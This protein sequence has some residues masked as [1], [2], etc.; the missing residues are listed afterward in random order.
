MGLG[1]YSNNSIFATAI[2]T[3]TFYRSWDALMLTLDTV[4]PGS[5]VSVGG[6]IS[7]SRFVD[8]FATILLPFKVPDG[9]NQVESAT[10]ISL[11]PALLFG[12]PFILKKKDYVKI[13]LVFFSFL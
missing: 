7:V 5:R 11:F 13:Y 8:L 4:Y 10:S 1:S 2:I 6:N 3:F 12:L 9:M